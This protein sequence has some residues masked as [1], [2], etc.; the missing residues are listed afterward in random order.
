MNVLGEDGACCACHPA[1]KTQCLR[2]F[3]FA[4]GMECMDCHGTMEAV[5]ELA[6]PSNAW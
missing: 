4:R 3:H 2:D 5:A 6:G 1:F